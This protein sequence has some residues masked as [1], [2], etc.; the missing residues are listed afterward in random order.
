[1]SKF[2]ISQLWEKGELLIDDHNPA[3][4][5]GLTFR[6]LQEDSRRLCERKISR[7][8]FAPFIPYSISWPDQPS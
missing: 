5:Y 4:S 8:A 2:Y 6:G 3:F 1:L 7:Q